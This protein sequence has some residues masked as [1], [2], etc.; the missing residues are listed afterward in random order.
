MKSSGK[1]TKDYTIMSEN[2]KMDTSSMAN[3]PM[4][5]SEIMMEYTP[6]KMSLP[7]MVRKISEKAK[8]K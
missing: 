2:P 7:Q 5:F 6:P 3:K 1:A 4:D 8:K